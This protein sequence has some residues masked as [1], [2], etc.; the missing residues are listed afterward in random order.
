M[1]Q[2]D[3]SELLNALAPALQAAAKNVVRHAYGPDGLPWH[4][5]FTAVEDIAVQVGDLLARQVLH[6]AL[7]GQ[8][9]CARPD[10]LTACPSCAGPLEQRPDQRRDLKARP[11]DLT[12]NEPATYCPRCRRAFFPSVQEPGP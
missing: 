12:W 6:L 11:G 10:D 4:T 7:Q 1:P 5:R 8:A 2:Q 9:A 3:A